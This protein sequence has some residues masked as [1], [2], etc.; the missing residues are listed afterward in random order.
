MVYERYM[1][2][3]YEYEYVIC[4]MGL[5]FCFFWNSGLILISMASGYQ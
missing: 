3:V 5:G 2:N 4:E 1:V